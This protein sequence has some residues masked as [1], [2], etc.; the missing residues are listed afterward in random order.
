MEL[1]NVRTREQAESSNTIKVISSADCILFSGGDQ[2]KISKVFSGTTAAQVLHK[3]L[4]EDPIVIAGTSAGAMVMSDEMIT[5]GSATDALFKGGVHMGEGLAFMPSMIIDSHFIM[6][7][8]FGRLVEALARYP[9]LIGI[10]LAED[11]GIV[12]KNCDQFEVIGSGMVILFDPSELGHNNFDVLEEG[13]P[14]S[15]SN[16]KVHVLASGDRFS[17][18]Q[19]KLEI[20]PLESTFE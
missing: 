6:R 14:M 9:Q 10:G 8:R 3:R 4:V 2:S 12:I 11:T 17:I 20:L 16:L 5:G 19:R 7:G 1:L 15:I 13:T 18:E